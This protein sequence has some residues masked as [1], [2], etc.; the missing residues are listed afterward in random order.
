MKNCDNKIAEAAYYI[1]QSQGC[2]SGMESV[3][4]N[5][6]VEQLSKCCSKSC[7]TSKKAPAKKV[8][9]ASKST[10]IKSNS[11]TSKS[12]KK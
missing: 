9:S 4:W 2:P 10:T 1:W 12:L 8:V 3:H 5:M 7:S 6:A 11:T